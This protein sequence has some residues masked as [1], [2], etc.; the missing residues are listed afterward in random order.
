M[1]AIRYPPSSTRPPCSSVQRPVEF[2]GVR[3]EETT[4]T[5]D[6]LLLGDRTS[7]V[8]DERRV[9]VSTLK[10]CSRRGRWWSMHPIAVQFFSF[11][12]PLS[13]TPRSLP[14]H[15]ALD[16]R[17]MSSLSYGTLPTSEV[18]R[19]SPSAASVPAGD[20]ARSTRGSYIQLF[21]AAGLVSLVV[22][23]LLLS[24]GTVSTSLS[25]R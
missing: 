12:G 11:T 1:L 2:L 19:E 15:L 18:A 21:T 7:C 5:R 10:V 17:R 4:S 22:C 16:A 3:M 8:E 23:A 25:S 6:V 20:D 9:L 24:S 14:H 13:L